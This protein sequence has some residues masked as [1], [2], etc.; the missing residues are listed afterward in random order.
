MDKIKLNQEFIAKFDALKQES[1]ALTNEVGLL[2]RQLWAKE[3][4]IEQIKE[5][6]RESDKKV[7]GVLEE[8]QKE[9]GVGSLDLNSYEF[10]PMPPQG[11]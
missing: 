4:A 5:A 6:I 1:Q 10:T 11:E 3:Q 8:V 9:H 2:Y 7:E